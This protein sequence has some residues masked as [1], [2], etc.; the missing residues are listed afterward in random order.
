MHGLIRE[1]FLV[2]SISTKDIARHLYTRAPCGKVVIVAEQPNSLL[3]A[4]R[5][6]WL[7]L[8]G[9]VQ[10]E[11]SSLL[12]SATRASELSEVIAKM[13][14]LRFTIKWPPDIELA[15]VYIATEEQLL[16][17]APE[18]RTLYITCPVELKHLY[19]ITA[20]MPRGGLVVTY[21]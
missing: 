3:S 16:Q 4:L 18:C 8:T 12:L 10:R 2:S 13:Q 11:R 21:A 1:E 17:W 14:N 9:K 6:Q 20:L 5:K 15:D 19:I 7:K